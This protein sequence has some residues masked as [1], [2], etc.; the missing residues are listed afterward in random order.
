MTHLADVQLS[1]EKSRKDMIEGHV[2]LIIESKNRGTFVINTLNLF[3]K[4]TTFLF[5]NFD[6]IHNLWSLL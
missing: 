5:K 6:H 1:Q 2:K 3:S 4:I